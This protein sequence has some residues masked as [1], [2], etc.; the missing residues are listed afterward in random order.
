[1]KNEEQQINSYAKYSSIAIQ[2]AAIIAGG[3]YSGIFLDEFFDVEIVFTVVF[4]LVSVLVA[5]YLAIKDIIKFT[6]K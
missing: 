6:N 2:M 4:S 1:M 3:T 5:M